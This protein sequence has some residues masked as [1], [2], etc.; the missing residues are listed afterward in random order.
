MIS[1]IGFSAKKQG[2]K[3]I[4]VNHL[5]QQLVTEFNP[6]ALNFADPLKFLVYETFVAPTTMDEG[7][8]NSSPFIHWITEEE[9][10]EKHPC[11]KTI[12]EL[13]QLFGTDWCRSVWPTIWLEHYKHTI[14]TLHPY[15]THVIT[16]DVRFPNE[17]ECIHDLGGIVIRLLR[18]PFK[19]EKIDLHSSEVAL[20]HYTDFDLVVDNSQMSIEEQN[21]E[22]DKRLVEMGVLK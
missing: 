12:R 22:L 9:K 6:I 20:D 7:G 3:T 18:N 11:G 15:R 10:G 8:E 5:F 21:Q 2:G 17:V 16:G 1:I 19:D 4:A 13:L 14:Q